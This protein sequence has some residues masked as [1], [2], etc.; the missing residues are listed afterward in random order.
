[1]KE[2]GWTLFWRF[3]I[4]KISHHIWCHIKVSTVLLTYWVY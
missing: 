3:I 4:R 1:M 2:A